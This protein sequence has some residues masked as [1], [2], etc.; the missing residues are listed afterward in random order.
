MFSLKNSNI[1]VVLLVG[2][3]L[4]MSVGCVCAEDADNSTVGNMG[5]SDVDYSNRHN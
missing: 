2:L 5:L 1:F 3:L 4:F